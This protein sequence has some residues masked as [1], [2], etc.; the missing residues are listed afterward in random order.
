MINS[1]SVSDRVKAI[2]DELHALKGNQNTSAG[3]LLVGGRSQI[4]VNETMTVQANV[5]KDFIIDI[6]ITNNTTNVPPITNI[7]VT[8][9]PDDVTW[10]DG[11]STTYC[12]S[13]SGNRTVWR[14]K[15]SYRLTSAATFPVTGYVRVNSLVDATLTYTRVA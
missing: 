7:Y 8:V 3:G 14:Y 4:S 15:T 13:A 11:G 9:F 6:T 1:G 5:W 12:T 2:T 10:V